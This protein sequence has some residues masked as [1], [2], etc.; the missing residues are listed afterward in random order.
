M[1]TIRLYFPDQI[2]SD[3]SSH[4]TDEQTHYVKDVMRLKIGDKISIFNALGEWQAIIESYEKNRAKIKNPTGKAR[5]IH[6]I[7]ILISISITCPKLKYMIVASIPALKKIQA[8]IK[9][10]K[11]TTRNKITFPLSDNKGVKKSTLICCPFFNKGPSNG[12]TNQLTK[13]GGSSIN[14]ANPVPVMNLVLALKNKA[15][16]IVKIINIA[17]AKDAEASKL[18]TARNAFIFLD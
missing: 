3:L 13:T 11:L 12:K 6:H 16:T 2:Q 4:L 9:A 18:L 10:T 17:R 1:S 8:E 15:A 14:Q 5:N 7:G